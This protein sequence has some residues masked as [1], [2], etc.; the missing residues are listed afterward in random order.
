[1][2]REANELLARGDRAAAAAKF[3]ESQRLRDA[4][5]QGETLAMADPAVQQTQANP[6][7]A[8]ILELTPADMPAPEPIPAPA[9][10]PLLMPEPAE[11]APEAFPVNESQ[12]ATVEPPTSVEPPTR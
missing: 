11:L 3:V 5:F 6:N 10:T 4:E 7:A 12:P 8:P 9:E 1:M 2:E